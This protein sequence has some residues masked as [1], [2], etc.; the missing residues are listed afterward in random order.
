MVC[1]RGGLDL[2]VGRDLEPLGDCSRVDDRAVVGFEVVSGCAEARYGVI[3]VAETPI[4]L[5][6]EEAANE[7][8]G[9]VV[10]NNEEGWPLSFVWF[11]ADGAEVELLD[12]SWTPD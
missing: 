4:A 2:D 9:V 10:V 6:A 12:V 1:A 11:P 7:A 3:V 5:V 8:G